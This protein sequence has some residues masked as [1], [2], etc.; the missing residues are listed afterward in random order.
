MKKRIARLSELV[1]SHSR[2][3]RVPESG[4]CAERLA[5]LTT[6]RLCPAAKSAHR[7]AVSGM[8]I[9]GDPFA[10]EAQRQRHTE[11]TLWRQARGTETGG[12]C[13]HFLNFSVSLCLCGQFLLSLDCR[14]RCT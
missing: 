13:S 4:E 6:W 8:C 12:F 7:C 9:D 11:K 5:R 2:R 3:V 14:R 1:R 10:T